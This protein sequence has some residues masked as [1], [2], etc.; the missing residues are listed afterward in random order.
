VLDDEASWGEAT[1]V[2]EQR[3][4]V[5]TALSDRIRRDISLGII[6]AGSR[7]NIDAL[8]REHKISHPSVREALSMLVGEGIVGA[9]EGKGFF[10]QD[11]SPE[12]QSDIA[13]VRAELE[14]LAFAW[15]ANASDRNWRAAIVA[16]HHALQEVEQELILDPVGSALEWDERN[17]N[18]HIAL[19]QN[20]GSPRLLD[21]VAQHYELGRRHRLAAHALAI[22]EN[23][24]RSWVET[25]AQEHAELKDAALEGDIARGQ[26]LLR[27]HITKSA[28]KYSA[29]ILSM[30]SSKNV[31]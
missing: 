8:K 23:E 31:E 18:F 20:C 1:S 24:R 27:N 15:S 2:G 21:L 14:C 13:R 9:A 11:F 16:A 22:P 19:T 17:A 4:S 5:S 26:G 29:L 7:L 25:S 10:V 28:N 12:E 30:N 3:K 6:P